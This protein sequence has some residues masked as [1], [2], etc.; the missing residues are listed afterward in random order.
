MA[1]RVAGEL[2][3]CGRVGEWGSDQRNVRAD[4]TCPASGLPRARGAGA[5]GRTEAEQSTGSAW[6]EPVAGVGVGAEAGAE[7]PTGLAHGP[8]GSGLRRG[9]ALGHPGRVCSGSRRAYPAPLGS[10]A[11]LVDTLVLGI[12]APTGWKPGR[13]AKKGP[14]DT[15]SQKVLRMASQHGANA[16]G[17]GFCWETP[18]PPTPPPFPGEIR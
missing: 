18:P 3:P 5:A 16:R 14:R 13:V 10:R 17:G 6:G 4:P 9:G 2:A 7:A 1:V 15:L 11:F 12:V 8:G